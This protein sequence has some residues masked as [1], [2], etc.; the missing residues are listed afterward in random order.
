MHGRLRLDDGP[1]PDDRSGH[2]RRARGTPLESPRYTIPSGLTPIGPAHW[3]EV[4]FA[5]DDPWLV[6]PFSAPDAARLVLAFDAWRATRPIDREPVDVTEE[7]LLSNP[8]RWHLR[9]IR[10]TGTWDAGFEASRFANVWLHVDYV[11]AAGTYR[12]RVV[13]TWIYPDA[14]A[15]GGYGHFGLYPG[16][17]R[18]ESME[19][20][21]APPNRSIDGL[22]RLATRATFDLDLAKARSTG[23]PLVFAMLDIDGMRRIN[24]EQGHL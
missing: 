16:E 6:G 22:T 11:P 1:H 14:S 3:V 20:L 18:P 13:G 9:R 10:V 17:L 24:D 5:H 21:A 23:V 7:E 4:I 15:E 8:A 12:V 2:A 19:I